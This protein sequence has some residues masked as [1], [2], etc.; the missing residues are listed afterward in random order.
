MAKI[1]HFFSGE[2]GAVEEHKRNK[3]WT[4]KSMITSAFQ[5]ISNSW[6]VSIFAKNL[7]SFSRPRR[8]E[9]NLKLF[10]SHFFEISLNL[11]TRLNSNS[12]IRYTGKYWIDILAESV[13][14]RMM[15]IG[16]KSE[17]NAHH[18]QRTLWIRDEIERI[19]SCM[20]HPHTHTR[21]S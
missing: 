7:W 5:T 2:Y 6:I 15:K 19:Q 20:H 3:K 9:L 17:R 4:V 11:W 14:M 8:F 13:D 16:K 18:I 1:S 21:T 12:C 10:S